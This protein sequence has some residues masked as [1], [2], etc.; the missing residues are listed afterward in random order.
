MFTPVWMLSNESCMDIRIYLVT[1]SE[2]LTII[3]PAYQAMQVQ[4]S[5]ETTLH[6][7]NLP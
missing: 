4:C 3:G 5:D 7:Y 2:M 1:L 6:T